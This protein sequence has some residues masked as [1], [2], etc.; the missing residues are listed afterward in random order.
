[1]E[2]AF[3][4]HLATLPLGLEDGVISF[5]D[6]ISVSFFRTKGRNEAGVILQRKQVFRQIT[7]VTCA[8]A[9][10]EKYKWYI[11]HFFVSDHF[12]DVP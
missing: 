8:Y 2:L 12:E 7:C 9:H 5:L 6:P 11:L 4:K 3:V 10:I 1:V